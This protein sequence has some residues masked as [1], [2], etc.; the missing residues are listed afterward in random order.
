MI[1]REWWLQHNTRFH[2]W[3]P[4]L[5]EQAAWEYLLEY[6]PS[7]EDI[8]QLKKSGWYVGFVDKTTKG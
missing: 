8:Q 4:F 5:T 1:K 7:D 2:G 6:P 3:G